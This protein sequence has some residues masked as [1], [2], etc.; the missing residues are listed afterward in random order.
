MKEI[1][2]MILVSLTAIL[3]MMLIISI[4]MNLFGLGYY[5]IMSGNMSIG[6]ISIAQAIATSVLLMLALI[7]ADKME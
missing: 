1:L 4:P 7:S 2:K 6:I 5:M 3:G